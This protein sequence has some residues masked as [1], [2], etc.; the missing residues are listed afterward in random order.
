MFKAVI[1]NMDGLMFDT[2]RLSKEL[3]WELA[4]K[5]KANPEIFINFLKLQYIKQF[6]V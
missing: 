6:W 5:S 2:E 3:W 4:K 1:F